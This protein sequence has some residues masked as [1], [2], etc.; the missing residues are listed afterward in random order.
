MPPGMRVDASAPLCKTNARKSK[1]E[2]AERKHD[3]SLIGLAL[4]A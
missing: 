4:E 2:T 1:H 3:L